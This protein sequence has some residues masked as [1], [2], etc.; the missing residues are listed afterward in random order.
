MTART[1]SNLINL[2]WIG[3]CLGVIALVPMC[4]NAAITYAH[5][6]DPDAECRSISNGGCNSSDNEA[7][8]VT[9][10][11]AQW[12]CFTPKHMEPFC[13]ENDH[14]VPVARRIP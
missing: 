3:T 10:T 1:I 7:E 12:N 11:G 8:C 2:V 6:L 4:R 13:V 5:Q 9:S 14:V